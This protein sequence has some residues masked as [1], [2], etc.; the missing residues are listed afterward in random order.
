MKL[1]IGDYILISCILLFSVAL[2]V[3]LYGKIGSE[4]PLNAVITVGGNIYAQIPLKTDKTVVISENGHQ[5]TVT[6]EGGQVYMSHADCRGQ[7]CVHQGRIK[8]CGESI[9]CL[10]NRVVVTVCGDGGY[11]SVSW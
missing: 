9:I 11:D 5:N 6:V 2:G 8:R 10:P 3:L 1:K 7:E 4:P